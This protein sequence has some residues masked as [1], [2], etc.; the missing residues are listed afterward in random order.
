MSN[1]F[2]AAF[3][4]YWDWPVLRDLYSS[5]RSFLPQLNDLPKLFPDA[6]GV[7][8]IDMGSQIEFEA[9]SLGPLGATVFVCLTSP[10]LESIATGF[11]LCMHVYPH[12]A[13]YPIWCG[14]WTST[15][16]PGLHVKA[17]QEEFMRGGLPPTLEH[18]QSFGKEA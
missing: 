16:G 6:Q 12:V 8:V 9:P 3:D 2:A 7:R 1:P 15:H 4:A 13:P 10:S 18:L 17:T 11:N 5:S 14:L